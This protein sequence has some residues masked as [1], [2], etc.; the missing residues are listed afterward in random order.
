MLL[1]VLVDTVV[2]ST[3]AVVVLVLYDVDWAVFVLLA[4][5]VATAVLSTYAVDVANVVV[6][7][8]VVLF[9]NEVAL[10]VSI[11]VSYEVV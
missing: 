3:Y 8:N 7:A 6:V 11:T 4:V 9:V 5:L 10:L 2:L 1:A